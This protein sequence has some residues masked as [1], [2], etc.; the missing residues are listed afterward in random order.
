[1]L[2]WALWLAFALLDWL[3]WGWRRYSEGGLW[4]PLARRKAKL[5]G[6]KAA[7][8]TQGPASEPPPRG[9]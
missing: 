8:P 2:A 6:K 3:K 5:G 9:E 4:R 1:M 7:P